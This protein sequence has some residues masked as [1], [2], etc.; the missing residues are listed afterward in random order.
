[1]RYKQNE[2]NSSQHSISLQRTRLYGRKQS[3]YGSMFLENFCQNLSIQLAPRYSDDDFYDIEPSED[4]LKQLL[5]FC[6]SSLLRHSLT[7]LL[8]RT[9]YE[10]V[11]HGK[12][13]IEIVFWRD[14]DGTVQGIK[15]VPIVAKRKYWGIK[16]CH[17]SGYDYSQ[18]RKRF[19]I[20]KKCL[21]SLD[22]RGSG[23]GLRHYK[24]LIRRLKSLDTLSISGLAVDS[25]AEKYYDFTAHWEKNEY[26]LLQF[27][28]KTCWMGRN[29]SN[30][31]L[32]E[33]Y[34]LYRSAQ[35]KAIAF[36]FLTYM[37]GRINEG[38]DRFA[39]DLGYRG[40]IVAKYTPPNY[41]KALD[42]YM[43]GDMH[44]KELFDFINPVGP[45]D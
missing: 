36:R 27:T 21:I 12:A 39:S 6:D 26:K 42:A 2:Y 16:T 29:Y 7:Q 30:Q 37:L 40:H 13:Y 19:R 5:L 44:V 31:H 34:L 45:T 9:V 1:M 3:L 24:K 23:I 8:N 38:L 22:V 35:Y 11:Q 10:L 18:K 41:E 14:K 32:S 25:K 4:R 20:D 33:S 17:F 28:R 15:F 43:K